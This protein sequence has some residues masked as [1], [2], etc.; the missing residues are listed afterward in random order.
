[1]WRPNIYAT[2]INADK[3]WTIDGEFGRATY[4][5]TMT[6]EE[7]LEEY[8]KYSLSCLEGR[9][10][11]ATLIAELNSIRGSINEQTYRTIRGQIISGD[12]DGA[13]T[14]IARISK[15]LGKKNA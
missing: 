9:V 6:K 10:L 12:I 4:P 1:M 3:R 11:R 7:V 8:T 2:F 13:W 14:G 15:K 5:S